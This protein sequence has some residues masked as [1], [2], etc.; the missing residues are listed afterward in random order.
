M[1]NIAI[2]FPR[3]RCI[4]EWC[5]PLY[6]PSVQRRT[7]LFAEDSS[8]A[9]EEFLESLGERVRLR[10]FDQYRGGLDCKSKS[11]VLGSTRWMVEGL[12]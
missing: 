4:D 10:D 2:L 11:G 12:Y 6:T 1:N 8:A 3:Y 9:F 5:H 7:C